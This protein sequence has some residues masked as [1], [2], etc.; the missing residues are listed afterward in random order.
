RG[1]K[2]AALAAIALLLALQT[3]GLAAGAQSKSKKLDIRTLSTR[4]DRVSGGDVLIEIAPP[5]A[6]ATSAAANAPY[7]IA[8]NGRN[9]SAAFRRQNGSLVGL[10]TG[11]VVGRNELKATA[12]AVTDQRVTLTNYPTAPPIGSRPPHA[13]ALRHT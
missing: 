5:S 8:L 11:L 6:S 2:T 4:A 3:S 7:T 13:P 12:W 1:M 9:V 10:V